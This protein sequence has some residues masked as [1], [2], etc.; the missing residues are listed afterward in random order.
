MCG[1]WLGLYLVLFAGYEGG[2]GEKKLAV[3]GEVPP[4]VNLTEEA[5]ENVL[6]NHKG[7]VLMVNFWATWCE[8]CRDE[9]PELV[10]FQRRFQD[11]GL[12][13]IT[14]SFDPPGSRAKVQKFLESYQANFVH[15]LQNFQNLTGFVESLDQDWMGTLPATFIYDRRGHLRKRYRGALKYEEMKKAVIPLL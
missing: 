13:V 11:Q 15:Y 5:W 9:F 4:V 12:D 7:R 3:G 1:Y 6:S 2:V 10:R 8:P 14:V